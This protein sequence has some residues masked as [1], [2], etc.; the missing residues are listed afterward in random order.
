[1]AYTVRKNLYEMSPKRPSIVTFRDAN[2]VYTGF[3]PENW[4]DRYKEAKMNGLLDVLRVK[5]ER[6]KEGANQRIAEQGTAASS[7]AGQW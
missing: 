6:D 4:G 5:E 2:G 1:V 7:A 3:G